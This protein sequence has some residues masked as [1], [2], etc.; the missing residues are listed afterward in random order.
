[1]STSP[2]CVLVICLYPDMVYSSKKF[3]IAPVRSIQ[4]L[5]LS[6][7]RSCRLSKIPAMED[8]LWILKYDV[9]VCAATLAEWHLHSSASETKEKIVNLSLQMSLDTS[10]ITHALC[11]AV[12]TIW[13]STYLD[14]LEDPLEIQI[15]CWCRKA[16]IAAVQHFSAVGW[17]VTAATALYSLQKPPGDAA[18]PSHDLGFLPV[19]Q[20]CFI[21]E[22]LL[23]NE[24]IYSK[25]YL[26]ANSPLLR[27]CISWCRQLLRLP[28]FPLSRLESGFADPGIDGELTSGNETA[29]LKDLHL[30][31]VRILEG[32][33]VT[34]LESPTLAGYGS[35]A[36]LYPKNVYRYVLLN[37]P[38]LMVI[39][40][41]HQSLTWWATSTECIA[42]WDPMDISVD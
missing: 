7:I 4:L 35:A 42:L 33:D 21:T 41:D 2:H 20:V 3:P 11:Q 13:K 17:C 40:F 38:S 25:L 1:M 16:H 32:T 8:M 28:P 26:A 6:C 19:S 24:S 10:A 34:L 30:S 9:A 22:P 31:L 36:E 5:S 12:W 39:R 23:G 15:R 14:I 18:Q 29:L 37:L 27:I